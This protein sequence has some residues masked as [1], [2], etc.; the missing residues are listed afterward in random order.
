M[1]GPIHSQEVLMSKFLFVLI[2]SSTL[3]W[4]QLTVSTLRGTATDQTRAVDT[5]SEIKVI[6]A[7]TNF[8]RSVTTNENGDF[9]ILDLPRDTYRL[10]ATRTGFKTFVDEN[11]VLESS[12]VRRV[13]VAF[14]VS[15]V[16]GEITVHADAAVI[17]TETGKI[18]EA[19]QKER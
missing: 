13:D 14:E 19:F 17:A 2:L 15:A 3:M 11:V 9:E 7:S 16:G 4:S 10:T 8:T 12:Q 1:L 18:Q 6:A 5:G